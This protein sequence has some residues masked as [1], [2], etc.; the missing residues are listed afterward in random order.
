M[1]LAPTDFVDDK[2]ANPL[3]LLG[4]TFSLDQLQWTVP[5]GMG[6]HRAQRLHFP[7][8]RRP[9]E[10]FRVGIHGRCG[11]EGGEAEEVQRAGASGGA[12]AAWTLRDAASGA[13]GA[14]RDGAGEG[15]P[16]GPCQQKPGESVSQSSHSEAAS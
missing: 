2:Y 3:A 10:Q 1:L 13:A 7:Q 4:S 15:F 6:G 16:K 9:S 12:E 14:A 11:L 8:R 5:G